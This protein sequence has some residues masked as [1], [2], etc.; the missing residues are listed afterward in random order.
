MNPQKTL[1]QVSSGAAF[2]S[3]FLGV[4]GFFQFAQLIGEQSPWSLLFGI[5]LVSGAIGLWK[6]RRGIRAHQRWARDAYEGLLWVVALAS[7]CFVIWVML[8]SARPVDQ[9]MAQA[10]DFAR[11]VLPLAA[12]PWLG[13]LA[14]DL[15]RVRRADVRALMGEANAEAR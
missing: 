11:M 8:P 6:V 3:F 10:Q 14:Y 4:Q 15:W 12:I 9:E 1:D 7:V 5:L 2:G 13:A